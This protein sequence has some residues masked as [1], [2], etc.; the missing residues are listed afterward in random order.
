L[1]FNPTFLE[2]F[3]INSGLGLI[4]NVFFIVPFEIGVKEGGLYAMLGF[5]NYSPA[6]GIFIGI[7]NR[8]RELVW[9]LI[10]LLL[11]AVTGKGSPNKKIKNILYGESDII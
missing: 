5:L 7:V 9:I 8:L 3:I 6:M 2:A 10:G 11:I 1:G 4:A